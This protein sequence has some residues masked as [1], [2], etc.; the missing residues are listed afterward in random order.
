M[1]HQFEHKKKKSK[2]DRLRYAYYDSYGIPVQAY[3]YETRMLRDGG[4]VEGFICLGLKIS[5]LQ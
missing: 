5:H 4:K 2:K 3:S 1:L